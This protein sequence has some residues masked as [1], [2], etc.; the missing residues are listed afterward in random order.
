MSVVFYRLRYACVFM[1]EIIDD[2]DDDDD[3]NKPRRTRS[4]RRPQPA[5]TRWTCQPVHC[6]CQH[7]VRWMRY[8]AG[9]RAAIRRRTHS[10]LNGQ[11][12]SPSPEL[13]IGSKYT[14]AKLFFCTSSVI[15]IVYAI[16]LCYCK[17]RLVD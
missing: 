14:K 7:R 6:P 2:D 3:V 8:A 11:E 15:I 16:I 9:L 12:E 10:D 17:L 4:W 5:V 13:S 1:R